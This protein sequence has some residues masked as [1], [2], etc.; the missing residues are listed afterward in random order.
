M[1]RRAYFKTYEVADAVWWRMAARAQTY[2]LPMFSP[3]IMRDGS[4]GWRIEWVDIS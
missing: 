4:K 1:M 3:V 2:G